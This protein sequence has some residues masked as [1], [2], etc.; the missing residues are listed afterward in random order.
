MSNQPAAP[1][2]AEGISHCLALLRTG[3][4]AAME[5]A[6]ERLAQAFP[7][8][9][10]AWQMLGVARLVAGDAARAVEPLE[11]ASRLA[12]QDAGVWDNLGAA[13]NALRRFDRAAACYDTSLGL[14]PRDPK[15]LSNAAANAGDA[16]RDADAHA[17]AARALALDPAL[18]HAHLALGNA[19]ARLGRHGEALA[20][21]RE[22]V[23]LAPALPQAH[24][25]LG[26]G[27]QLAG[28][29]AGAIRAT[30]D[31]L[32]IAPG[33]ADAQQ[34]LGRYH[35]DLGDMAAAA[36]HYRAALQLAPQRL[37]AWSGWLFCLAHDA[38]IDAAEL[39]RAH[40]E[41]GDHVE[42]PL[43]ARWGGWL[44]ARDPH[45]RLRVGF[46]SGDLRD[47]AVAHFVQPIWRHLDR[48]S[49]EIIAYA[50]QTAEDA[51]SAELRQLADAWHNVAALDDD[52][53]E[54]AIRAARI[55]IL[56]DLS[57]HT[58]QHRLGVFARKPAPLQISWI[59]Y[60]NTTGLT[61]IDYRF[62]GRRAALPGELDAQF[63]ERLVHLPV[64]TVFQPPP[65]LPPV[66]PLPAVER[67]FLTFGN[68]NRPIK[69]TDPVIGLWSAVLRALPDSRML[70]GAVSNDEV[71][72]RLT[73][74]FAQRGIE[75]ARLDFH[76]RVGLLEYLELHHEIDFILDTFPFTGG[77][78]T[79]Q[80]LWMGVPTLTLTGETL[81]QRQGAGIMARAGL[82]E[83]IAHSPADFVARAVNIAGA[84]H[85]LAAL[86]GR[87]R[88]NC[89]DYAE[90]ETAQAARLVETALRTMWQ[91]W[92]AGEP[93]RSFEVA[94]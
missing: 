4:A 58:A 69:L 26:N 15:V 18:A 11:Q 44:N 41:F 62:I 27:L 13:H 2:L 45:K 56:F 68:F 7:A 80:A 47:H 48:E 78:T 25:S 40:R 32:R 59:G 28:D 81:P 90:S 74:A 55:D 60:P 77:T 50:T 72:Q 38:G 76:P 92:C 73:R 21:L 6:A 89:E 19:A 33:F 31:A 36:R 65:D 63:S 84:P 91:R 1:G 30:E 67:G 23:R 8:A 85:E 75:A 17:Y 61:A 39:F 57:G 9:A 54:A 3:Q 24:L 22:A 49:I 14:D 86:R 71:R 43:R 79:N 37:D 10:P 94:P 12:P 88:G 5:A 52:G 34:N 53:L 51:R 20:A 16:G 82:G 70:I 35:H 66:N 64:G 83:W 87:L 46:V 93:A 42:A 29:T